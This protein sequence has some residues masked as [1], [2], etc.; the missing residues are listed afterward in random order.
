LNGILVAFDRLADPDAV[1]VAD[2]EFRVGHDNSPSGWEMAPAPSGFRVDRGVALPPFVDSPDV[3]TVTWEDGAIVNQWLQVTVLANSR[4]GLAA[5]D[6]FYFGNAIGETGDIPGDTLVD[7]YDVAA[8]AANPRGPD[9]PATI[10]DP[11]DF[12]RDGLVD[13]TD[14]TLAAVHSTDPD[15]CLWLLD[16]RQPALPQVSVSVSPEIVP[17]TGPDPLVYTFTRSGATDDP[18]TATFRVTG[19]AMYPDDYTVSGAASFSEQLGTVHLPPAAPR[20][21]CWSI[22]LRTVWSKAPKPSGCWC[23]RAKP[24]RSAARPVRSAGSPT[25]RSAGRGSR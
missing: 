15:T 9:D 10:T 21:R 25:T 1:T 18:V 8:V 7:A 12:N 2:F 6:V 13:E 4:T 11:Y 17:E 22:R 24:L 14:Q 19:T 16:L 3:V 20:P 5:A 23:C